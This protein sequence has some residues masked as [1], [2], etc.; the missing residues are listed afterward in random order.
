MGARYQVKARLP[1]GG[2]AE[3]YRA[4]DRRLGIEVVIKVPNRS[5]FRDAT[6]AARFSQEV[7][8]LV[9][10]AHPHV[11]RVLDVGEHEG[12]PFAVLPYLGGGSLYDRLMGPDGA[13]RL[14]PVGR[15]GDWLEHIAEALDFI[16]EQGYVHRDV[17][18]ANILFDSHGN[19]F[20]SDL[21]V[22][23][24]VAGTDRSNLTQRGT[25]P[26][27]LQYIPPEVFRGKPADGRV[28]QYALAV[29]VYEVLAGRWPFDGTNPA[30]LVVQQTRQLPPALGELVPG[31]PEAV[32]QAVARALAKEPDQRFPDCR[33]FARAVLG[34][35]PTPPAPALSSFTLPCPT[36]CTSLPVPPAPSGAE[37]VACP[38]CQEMLGLAEAHRGK[39]V[40]CASCQAVLHVSADLT[41]VVAG[42]VPASPQNFDV[43][44][45]A[46]A[47]AQAQ[48]VNTPVTAMPTRLGQ[49]VT[50]IPMAAPTGWPG[51]GPTALNPSPTPPATGLSGPRPVIFLSAQGPVVPPAV[52]RP[53]RKGWKVGGLLTLMLLLLGGLG[54]GTYY[55]L[56][57]FENAFASPANDTGSASKQPPKLPPKQLPRQVPKQPPKQPQR[58]RR[59]WGDV[60][61]V[62][63]RGDGDYRTIGEALKDARDGNK[64][65][66]RPGV[67]RES[68]R[69]TKRVDIR[70]TGPA[71]QVIIQSTGRPCVVVQTASARLQSL[72]LVGLAGDGEPGPALDIG[73]GTVV[74]EECDITS[75][76]LDG[77]IIHGPEAN[78][79]LRKCVIHDSKRNGVLVHGQARATLEECELVQN[80]LAGVA[81]QDHAEPLLRRCRLRNGLGVGLLVSREGRGTLED[82]DITGNADVGVEIAAAGAPVL[83]NCRIH[84]GKEGGVLVAAA[85]GTLDDCRIYNNG[86]T[87]LT[88][89]D[90]A[91]PV[92]RRC[93]IRESNAAG[94]VVRQDAGGRLE[95]CTIAHNALAGVEIREGGNPT[96]KECH[97]DSSQEAGLFVHAH[98]KGTMEGCTIRG[99]V[100]AGVQVADASDPVLRG[101]TMRDGLTSGVLIYRKG[102]GTLTDCDIAG[103]GL[104]GVEIGAGAEPI[105]R[106]CKIH[107]GKAGGIY[108]SRD[109]RGTI[110]DCDIAGN[111]LANIAVGYGADPVIRRCKVHDGKQGGIYV[112]EKAKGTIEDCDVYANALAGV[113]ISKGA[114]PVLRKCRLHDG[115]VNGLY[116]DANG[117][118]S[119]ED[120]TITDNGQNGVD[121][122]LGGAPVVRGCTIRGNK[123]VGVY[124]AEDGSGR[125]EDCDV[126]GNSE[127]AWSV[128]ARSDVERKGNRD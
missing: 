63:Q 99:N 85:A 39:R 109:G 77:V 60:L 120:C 19:V 50:S 126:G 114:D 33:S 42:N 46:P 23:K 22:A 98:G 62:S 122:R 82:C 53:G 97:I 41:R 5:L 88:I 47:T 84:H 124:V 103:N 65:L 21:G 73:Q 118:G 100:S 90:K 12:L 105:V 101:C 80:T 112:F 107:D 104:A 49:P 123:R 102:K 28:D 9:R 70:G 18:P 72:T 61:V 111:A 74:V 121:I 125:I 25:V 67:Y 68:I 96:L 37:G 13:R 16:H 31:L 69:L 81:V 91:Q 8:S 115:Q 36:T 58:P 1:G 94:V 127:G 52:P 95:G 55:V 27:T 117:K 40:R 66:V 75:A 57:W 32:S 87:G 83:R 35:V 11:V 56:P 4:W 3:V 45:P 17:K 108:V 6:F 48:L 59:P 116:V 51:R 110:E 128:S 34:A 44:V 71:R 14:V 10:L 29:T 7:C 93:T 86:G 119:I 78:P 92:V 2:M 30:A 15:L 43:A 54:V 24:A 106:H 79:V 26:G 64:I 89:Q 76:A 113:Q 20:L 38:L